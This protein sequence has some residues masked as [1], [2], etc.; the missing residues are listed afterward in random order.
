MVAAAF[1]AGGLAVGTPVVASAIFDARNA[2][3]V[4]GLHASQLN[5]IQYFEADKTFNDFD[6]CAYTT[7]MTRTFRTKHKG[8]VSVQGEVSAAR[9]AGSAAEGI[10]TTR[11]LI[12]GQVASLPAS[13]NL[14]NDGIL[15][16]TSSTV[17]ARQVS[18]GAHTLVLE[19][20]E[21]G[22]GMAFIT[23]QAMLASYSP[24][25]SAGIPPATRQ[26]ARTAQNR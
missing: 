17:G 13:V 3:R 7:L 10:L 20:Q 18:A 21:C 1:T 26:P 6:T 23:S 22:P 24:F 9:D 16:A 2:H 25:G 11:L 14:E 15:D 8:V 4:D 19:G 5:K 12:D